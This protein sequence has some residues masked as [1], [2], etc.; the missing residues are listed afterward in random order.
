MFEKFKKALK[1]NEKTMK[2]LNTLG[3]IWLAV[4][5]AKPAAIPFRFSNKWKYCKTHKTWEPLV[6]QYEDCNGAADEWRLRPIFHTTGGQVLGWTFGEAAAKRLAN[7]YDE[8]YSRVKG[9]IL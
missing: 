4:V 1:N 7:N 6:W 8:R 3:D 2:Y 9:I 5:Y